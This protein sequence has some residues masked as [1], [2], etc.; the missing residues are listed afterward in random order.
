[1]VWE[2][3][4]QGGDGIA[5]REEKGVVAECQEEL[6]LSQIALPACLATVNVPPPPPPPPPPP[7]GRVMRPI[8]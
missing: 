2:C 4:G 7:E 3:K 8:C 6:L 5:D 1:M